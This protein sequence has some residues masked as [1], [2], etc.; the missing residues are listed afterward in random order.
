[1]VLTVFAGSAKFERSLIIGQHLVDQ[2]RPIKSLAGECAL[3]R[4]ATQRMRGR[5]PGS[6]PTLRPA[7]R[8]ARQNY[9][10]NLGIHS[11]QR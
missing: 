1:M 11:L 7:C 10:N 4:L 6:M 5:A 3:V 8:L 9:S 2:P